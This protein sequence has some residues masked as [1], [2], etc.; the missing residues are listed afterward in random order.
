MPPSAIGIAL[1]SIGAA[2]VVTGLVVGGIAKGR[3][4]DSLEH[5]ADRACTEEGLAM[6]DEAIA[7][8]NAATVVFSIGLGVLA[9]GAGF[10]LASA[11]ME[12]D[13]EVGLHGVRVR[14]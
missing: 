13:V 8:G 5:C 4:D 6:Q 3:H 9:A 11:L 14:Y 12:D 2:G 7:Q 1:T 10:W